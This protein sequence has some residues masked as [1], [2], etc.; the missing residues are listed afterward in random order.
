MTL[1]VRS[2]VKD[3]QR[4]S[5]GQLP[6]VTQLSLSRSPS[7]LTIMGWSRSCCPK[8]PCYGR[9]NQL[10]QLWDVSSHQIWNMIFWSSWEW[11]RVRQI[12]WKFLRF[13]VVTS[14]TSSQIWLLICALGERS[15]DRSNPE[16]FLFSLKSFSCLDYED[17]KDVP[18]Q[19]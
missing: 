7:G 11:K 18:Y 8:Q 3:L 4:T 15:G 12:L 14:L 13:Q 1:G 2:E 9:C 10:M 16:Q 6:K 5:T 19:S 17:V